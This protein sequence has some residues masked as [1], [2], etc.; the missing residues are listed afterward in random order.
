MEL[1]HS[2]MEEFGFVCRHIKIQFHIT[3][4]K[5]T[6]QIEPNVLWGSRDDVKRYFE[7]L[8]SI[9]EKIRS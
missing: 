9:I 8:K 4:V 7:N 5:K 1:K 3:W 6:V 2:N